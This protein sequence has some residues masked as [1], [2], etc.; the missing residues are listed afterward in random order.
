MEHP[1]ELESESVH[2]TGN[3][4]EKSVQSCMSSDLTW[5]DKWLSIPDVSDNEVSALVTFTLSDSE[6][7]TGGVEGYVSCNISPS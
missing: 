7:H 5:L 4:R 2:S 3:G 1:E 6:N